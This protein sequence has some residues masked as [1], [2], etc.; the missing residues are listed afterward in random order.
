[1]NP[2][3]GNTLIPEG[4]YGIGLCAMQKDQTNVTFGGNTFKQG[5]IYWPAKL[6]G[7]RGSVYDL[8][9]NA[10]QNYIQLR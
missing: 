8:A 7:V 6:F 3:S 5:I 9:Q 4:M 2:Q 10:P 1:M